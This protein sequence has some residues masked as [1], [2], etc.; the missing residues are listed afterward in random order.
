M[1]LGLQLIVLMIHLGH[2]LLRRGHFAL[3]IEHALLSR[4][5]MLPRFSL[6]PLGVFNF[7]LKCFDLLT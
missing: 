1:D 3:K 6:L 2:L 4:V 7:G 5:G